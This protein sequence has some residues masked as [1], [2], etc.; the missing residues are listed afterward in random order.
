M[1]KSLLQAYKQ[2]PWRVQMQWIGLFLLAL[3]ILAALAGVYLNINSKAASSG[4]NIQFLE[5]NI[6]DINNNIA[7][8]TT[9]L[10][11]AESTE[12]MMRRAKELGFTL[13]NPQS[14]V[15]LKVPGYVPEDELVLAPPRADIINTT[16]IIQSAYKDSLWDWFAKNIWLISGSSSEEGGA[17]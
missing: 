11:E 15:Y 4:R 10:A 14:A 3:V 9:K 6:E 16:P 12:R 1:K 7:E 13:I 5:S 8:L 17:Q 2:A